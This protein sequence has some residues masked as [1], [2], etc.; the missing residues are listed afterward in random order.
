MSA[1]ERLQK[2][3]A[4]AGYGSRRA[5]EKL[6]LEGRVSVAGK[7]V[8]V[9][10]SRADPQ[11]QEIRVDGEPVRAEKPAYFLLHKP[12]GVICSTHDPA[13]R[14]LAVKLIDDPRRLFTVGRLDEDSEGLLLVTNDGELANRLTHPRHRVEKTYRARVDGRVAG[15]QLEQ[16]RRG[17]WLAEGRTA[18]VEVT[19]RRVRSGSSEL[20]LKLREGL[21]RQVRRMLAAAGLRCRRLKRVGLGPLRLG[22]LPS[23]AYRE[24]TGSERRGLWSAAET[25]AGGLP[26]GRRYRPP[27][28]SDRSTAAGRPPR[29]KGQKRRPSG[30]VPGGEKKGN[31]PRRW[32]PGPG[33]KKRGMR[34]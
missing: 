10:G 19:V 22:D 6:I 29:L 17:V 34:R 9:L 23:G 18:P 26:P 28:T 30:N 8:R 15:E 24:L 1:E 21:N 33:S 4:R 11:K 27:K 13:G 20:E 2:I 12:R 14:P 7:A 32:S 3:L 5:C 16:L 31:A 25:F